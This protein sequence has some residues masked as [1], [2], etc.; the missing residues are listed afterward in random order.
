MPECLEIEHLMQSSGSLRGATL[1][2]LLNE[3]ICSV[4]EE[5]SDT[6]LVHCNSSCM[7][8]FHHTCIGLASM[9]VQQSFICD[10]CTTGWHYILNE[11]LII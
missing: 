5:L 10:E 11:M 8:A 3:E 4:C 6:K 1:T 7:R 2:A 9:P